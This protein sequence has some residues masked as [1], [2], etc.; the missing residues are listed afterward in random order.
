[1]NLGVVAGPDVEAIPEASGGILQDLGIDAF[2]LV[3]A[4]G[5]VLGEGLQC[6]PVLGPV[7]PD[8]GLC[9]RGFLEVECQASAPEGEIPK[10]WAGEPSGVGV[11]LRLPERADGDRLHGGTSSGVT[12]CRS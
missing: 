5:A 8:E 2:D 7:E 3:L 6:L 1:M 4:E 11:E 12:G 10:A 9:D